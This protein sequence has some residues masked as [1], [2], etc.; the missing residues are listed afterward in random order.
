MRF[1]RTMAQRKILQWY[2]R[3]NEPFSVDTLL[4]ERVLH[5]RLLGKV[6]LWAMERKGQIIQPIVEDPKYVGTTDSSEEWDRLY[7]IDCHF[8][9]AENVV[10]EGTTR[11]AKCLAQGV[12]T[13]LTIYACL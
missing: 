3:K 5:N 4:K 1:F 13:V 9:S 2:W 10:I 12:N 6:S 7:L 11:N 8:F